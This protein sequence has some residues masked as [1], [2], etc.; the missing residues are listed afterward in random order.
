LGE[1]RENIQ[2]GVPELADAEEEHR[3]CRRDD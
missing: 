2:W 1:L 3:G